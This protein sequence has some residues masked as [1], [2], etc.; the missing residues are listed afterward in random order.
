MLPRG[1]I[2]NIISLLCDIITSRISSPPPG[3][4]PKSLQQGEERTLVTVSGREG[5]YK[6]YPGRSLQWELSAASPLARVLEA[7][8]SHSSHQVPPLHS[9]NREIFA[10]APLSPSSVGH[11]NSCLFINIFKY[12]E[13]RAFGFILEIVMGWVYL[14]TDLSD[15]DTM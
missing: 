8:N 2:P 12:F 1:C 5:N 15:L 13:W 3:T 7:L 6:Q 4:P 14:D 10:K 9:F 11:G